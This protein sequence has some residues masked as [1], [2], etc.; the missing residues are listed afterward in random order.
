MM[1]EASFLK[2]ILMQELIPA[3]GCTEVGAVALAARWAVRA[4][5]VQMDGVESIEIEVDNNTYKN[6]IGVGIPGTGETGLGVAAAMG[7]LAST[8]DLYGLQILENPGPMTVEKAR[9]LLVENRVRIVRAPEAKGILIRARARSGNE[10]ASAVIQ[11]S[12]DHLVGVQKNGKPYPGAPISDKDPWK[13]LEDIKSLRYGD[14]VEYASTVDLEELPII[15]QALRMNVHFC[16]E[17]KKGASSQKIGQ[18]VEKCASQE[19]FQE[20]LSVKAQF[21][22]ALAVEARMKGLDLPVMT[23]AGSGN[24]GLVATIPVAEIAKNIKASEER[25]LRALALSYLTTIYIKTFTGILS[26]ICGC[27]VAAA[28]GAGCGIVFLHGGGVSQIE[29]Q[30]NNMVGAMAGIICDGAKS[31]CAFKAL[32]AVGLALDSSYLSMENVRIPSGDGI[33]GNEVLD[34]LKNLQKIIQDGMSSMD[35]A[36][37]EIMDRNV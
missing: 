8:G 1:K 35:T 32:M 37:I 7:A 34:T 12:H 28:V 3:T 2:A 30:I 31:G 21:V 23:C 16:E 6:A 20:N 36:I 24:Q 19:A 33:M 27:G 14:L 18:V 5:D 29:A 10:E 17:A 25:L 15:H 26:P 22:T 4:L 13:L 11:G 9:R